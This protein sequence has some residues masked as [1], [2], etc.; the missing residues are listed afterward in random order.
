MARILIACE[1]SGTVRE[2]FKRHGWDAW[3]CDTE[4]GEIPGQHYRCDVR[5]ILDKNW[6][7]MICHPPCKFLAQSGLHWNNR[8]RGW[9][10]T[11]DAYNFAMMLFHAPIR[12]ICMENSIGY[13]STYFRKPDQI[14]QPYDFGHDAS[15]STCLW[16]KNLPLLT[17]TKH[18]PGV[19]VGGRMVWGNQTLSGQNNLVP[20]SLRWMDRARTYEGIA[21]AMASQWTKHI[22]Q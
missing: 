21:E 12:H 13:L 20:G 1:Y 10:Q 18:I 19:R 14:I 6:D 4:Y 7:A 11:H 2:A 5:R 17:P 9:E 22:L 3:S 8:G 16:L 15:K